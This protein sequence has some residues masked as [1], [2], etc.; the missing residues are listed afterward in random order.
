[1]IRWP[2]DGQPCL[3]KASHASSKLH[4]ILHSINT[5]KAGNILGVISTV[6]LWSLLRSY[7]GIFGE[8]A[9]IGNQHGACRWLIW[10]TCYEISPKFLDYKGHVAEHLHQEEESLHGWENCHQYTKGAWRLHRSR[11]EHQILQQPSFWKKGLNVK[12]GSSTPCPFQRCKFPLILYYASNFQKIWTFHVSRNAVLFASKILCMILQTLQENHHQEAQGL[13]L[14][15][16]FPTVRDDISVERTDSIRK[17]S[18][19]GLLKGIILA[20]DLGA[21]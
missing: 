16:M 18:P 5:P 2:T 9:S 6:F 10:K 19:K 11:L 8:G 15:Q 17:R 14:D 7:I 1:M 12:T 21:S 4:K 20:V 13:S 3:W